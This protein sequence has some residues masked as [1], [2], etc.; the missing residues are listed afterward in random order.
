MNLQRDVLR[1]QEEAGEGI[2]YKVIFLGE[3]MTALSLTYLM[4]GGAVMLSISLA[5]F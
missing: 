3:S 2:L 5:F 1:L 4:G